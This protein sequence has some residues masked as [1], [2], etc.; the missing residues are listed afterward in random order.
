MNNGTILWF[1]GLSGSGKTTLA[2]KL[3]EFVEPAIILDG[4]DIRGIV[5]NKDFSIAGRNEHIKRMGMMAKL[6][7]NQGINVI[8]TFISPTNEAREFAK[9][10]HDKFVLIYVKCSI[11]ECI[12]RDV[13]GLYKKAEDG[14]IKNMT[15]IGQGYEEPVY[16]DL[17][18]DTEKYS[19]D[20]CLE[21]LTGFL[22]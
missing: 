13:K 21:E 1:T 3:K 20:E 16:P 8:C 9:Q 6:F 4:D 11:E 12:K 5:Q 18:L 10:L 2:K 17:I 15:G 19:V 7:A 14:T 22:S